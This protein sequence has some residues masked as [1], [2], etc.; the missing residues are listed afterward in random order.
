MT[1]Y[2]TSELE[3]AA[4]LKTRGHRLVGA[5]PNGRLVTFEFDAS[6]ADDANNYFSGAQTPARDLFEAHR[7]LRALIQQV[8][9]HAS[10]RNVSE[11]STN[12]RQPSHCR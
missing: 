7:S 2:R 9:E 6:A 11:P 3:L 8:R 12:E 10:Q 4:F 1:T 5:K